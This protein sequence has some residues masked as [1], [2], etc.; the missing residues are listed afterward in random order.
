MSRETLIY[1]GI[2]EAGYGPMLGPLCVG[3]S[4]FEVFDHTPAQG[5]PDLWQRLDR[6]CCRAGE[7]RDG[8]IAVDDSKKLLGARSGKLH[9]LRR[10]ERGVHGFLPGD[11]LPSTDTRLF[12]SLGTTPGRHAWYT[13]ET[14]LPLSTDHDEMQVLRAR[15]H[16]SLEQAGVRC[17]LIRC[18][19]VDPRE[20]NHEFSR[21]GS[22]A[23]INFRA[24]MRLVEQIWKQ[25]PTSHPR[26]ILDR[27][28]G[29]TRYLA[30]LRLAY[31]D[32]TI[33]VL[34]ESPAISRYRIHIGDRELT[35]SF[36]K[37]A[38]QSHFPVALASMTA[39]Y[40]RELHM[41]RLNRFFQTHLPELKPTAGYVQDGRRFLRDVQPILERL[42][43]SRDNLVRNA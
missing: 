23:D 12:D 28:G 37:E 30:P 43:I 24:A 25:H 39:K 6:V 10:L 4:V 19:A 21:M 17:T 22:K 32:A 13:S 15:L 40:I 14:A 36:A 16:R 9:P 8:R 5:A 3:A 2:D 11:A 20:F 29:R 18:E 1:A 34:A 7:D 26:V 35:I 41:L 38:E 33:Q 31:P 27:H 42:S